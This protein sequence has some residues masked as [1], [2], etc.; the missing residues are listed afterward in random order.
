MAS[1]GSTDPELAKSLWPRDPSILRRSTARAGMEW[2]CVNPRMG[3]KGG[4][5]FGEILAKASQPGHF[6]SS[7]NELCDSRRYFPLY[8]SDVRN[9][10]NGGMV[11]TVPAHQGLAAGRPFPGSW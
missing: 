1:K 11:I 6:Q 8:F 7:P 5:G 3:G 10:D 9:G 2:I 4:S